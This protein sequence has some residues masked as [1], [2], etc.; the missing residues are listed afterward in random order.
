[1]I[2]LPLNQKGITHIPC[3]A[4]GVEGPF[5][6]PP[7]SAISFFSFLP[8][9]LPS[10]FFFNGWF[11]FWQETRGSSLQAPS[12]LNPLKPPT[13]PVSCH[14]SVPEPQVNTGQSCPFFRQLKCAPQIL[15]YIL[16]ARPIIYLT[17]PEKALEWGGVR[18]LPEAIS[19]TKDLVGLEVE[20]NSLLESGS[21]LAG[22]HLKLRGREGRSNGP[23]PL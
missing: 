16:T 10:R 14:P 23:H 22:P 7:S 20:V 1:M 5:G 15:E 13:H 21:G 2:S 9:L 3:R 18:G 17:S 8:L 4:I 11:N 19:G 6:S 12:L